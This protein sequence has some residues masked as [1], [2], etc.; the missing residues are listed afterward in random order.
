MTKPFQPLLAA[1]CDDISKLRY[2][3][4]ASP[5]LDGIRCVKLAGRALTRK[6][7]PV[8]NDFI[9]TWIE[10]NLP[11]GIDGEIMLRDHRAPFSEV[12]SA[13]MKKSGEPNFSFCAF[14]FVREDGKF[15]T[16]EARFEERFRVLQEIEN[17]TAGHPD[18]ACLRVVPH[19]LCGS[20][21]HLRLWISENLFQGYEGTM[22]RDPNGRYKFGRSTVK[23][24][25]LLKIKPWH[26]E[27]ATVIGVVEQ[28]HNTNEATL[29][30]RGYTK[31]SSAKEGK[32]GTGKLGALVCRTED[33][34]EFEIGTGFTDAQR[35]D[36]WKAILQVRADVGDEALPVWVSTELF[37]KEGNVLKFKHQPPPG[38]RKPGEAP[39]FPVFLGW[40]ED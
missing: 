10:A 8:P 9:R 29:D 39:R 6:L 16:A 3:V 14:D 7:K 36:W 30:E 5:K 1:T 18:M 21:E 35:V 4:L 23:E 37:L 25:I 31:R 28:M 15:P 22:V 26:D 11:D 27:E 34:V 38:G 19:E 32:V 33:G 24:G 17:S 2:P 13:V 40:R 12:S 20:A